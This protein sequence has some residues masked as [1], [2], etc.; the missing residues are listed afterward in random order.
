[1][2]IITQAKIIQ[3]GQSDSTNA[4]LILTP[5]TATQP[6]LFG[7]CQDVE[8]E[9]ANG[10][11]RVCQFLGIMNLNATRA[12]AH[13]SGTSKVSNLLCSNSTLQDRTGSLM[14]CYYCRGSIK[15]F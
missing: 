12:Q 9:H 10:V 8:L 11:A 13:V 1:M 7:P 3:G 2:Y 14:H 15:S 6:D 4:P 5:H